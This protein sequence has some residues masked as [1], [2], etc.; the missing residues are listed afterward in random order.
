[1]FVFGKQNKQLCLCEYKISLTLYLLNSS[2]LEN[3][4]LL[5]GNKIRMVMQSTFTFKFNPYM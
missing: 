2:S 1:M 5:V 4:C 3:S